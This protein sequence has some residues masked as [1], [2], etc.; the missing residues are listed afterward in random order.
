MVHHLPSAGSGYRA[1]SVCLRRPPLLAQNLSL[2]SLQKV[3]AHSTG[4]TFCGLDSESR[5]SYPARTIR[6]RRQTDTDVPRTAG[7]GAT[8]LGTEA[9]SMDGRAKLSCP[10]F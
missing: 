10:Q 3:G 4:V 7:P 8:D 6:R 2:S 9:W 1:V 5:P